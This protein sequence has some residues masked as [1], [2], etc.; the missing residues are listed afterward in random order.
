[1]PTIYQGKCSDCGHK[2]P[3]MPAGYGAVL[4]DQPVE[5][6]QAQVVGAVLSKG[7]TGG[8]ATVSDSHLVV[9]SHPAESRILASAGFTWG[10]LRREGRYIACCNVVCDA[11]GQLFVLKELTLPQ[12]CSGCILP[13]ALGIVAGLSTGIWCQSVWIGWFASCGVVYLAGHC[14]ER[15]ARRRLE[16][17]YPERAAALEAE[18]FCPSCGSEENSGVTSPTPH[19][20]KSCKGRSLQF[21]IVG[22]S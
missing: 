4:V 2:T 13:L 1:M 15:M 8:F 14:M 22:K 17:Y 7:S 16:G 9:L 3:H 18:R 21:Q 6:D 20:C 12:G 11:C 19:R 5:R 10:D